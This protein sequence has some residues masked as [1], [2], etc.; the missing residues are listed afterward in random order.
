MDNTKTL[1][2]GKI[3]LKQDTD[4]FG[5][6]L[7]A[8]LITE[9]VRFFTNLPEKDKQFMQF[10]FH[11]PGLEKRDH[12]LFQLDQVTY[13][14]D[15]RAFVIYVTQLQPCDFILTGFFIYTRDP[16]YTSLSFDFA[17][18][19]KVVLPA[20]LKIGTILHHTI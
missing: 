17:I 5:Y 10:S 3:Q 12:I 20:S 14:D 13:G 1:Y 6:D 2:N 7:A 19:Y 9:N 18:R 8:P 4:V 16:V 11:Y 15:E